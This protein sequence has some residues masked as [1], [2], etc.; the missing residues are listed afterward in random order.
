MTNFDYLKQVDALAPLHR[1]C[2]KVELLMS[3]DPEVSAL[4]ARRALDWIVKAV[5]A[6]KGERLSQRAS[7]FEM[8][9]SDTFRDFINDPE[10][11]KAVHWVRKVGNHA[12]H[13]AA[14]TASEAFYSLLNIYNVVKAILLKLRVFDSIA[15]FDRSLV[16]DRPRRPHIHVAQKPITDAVVA[17]ETPKNFAKTIDTETVEA[18]PAVVANL[19]WSDIDE[20]ETRRLLIDLMVREAGWDILADKGANHPGKA[21]IE[22]EVQGMP[23]NQGVGYCDYVLFGDNGKPLAVIEAKRCSVNPHVGEEQ[24][25][26]YA[27]CLEA[28]YGVRPVIYFTNGY[29]TWV[30]D[31][32]GYPKRKIY[33]FHSKKNLEWLI[34]QRSRHNIEDMSVKENIA[35]RHYQKTAVKR[36]C[37]HFNDMHRRGLLVMATGTGKTRTAISLVDV[38]QRAGWVKNTLFLADRILLVKQ[39]HKNFVKLLPEVT[40]TVLSDNDNIPNL[41]ARIIFSTYQTMINH[42][43]SD[44]K[45]FPVGRFDLIIIDEAHRS[46]FGK[47][48]AIFHYF[49]SLLIG[50]TATPRDQVDKSTYDLLEL[51]G[52]Q[53]NFTYELEEAVADGYLVPPVGLKRNS[54]VL[55]DGIRYNQLSASEREQL[56]KVWEYEATLGDPGTPAQPRD[57]LSRELY[58]YIF[59]DKTIDLVLQDLMANGI[60][61]DN[62]EKIGKTIIFAFNK[63]HAELIVKRFNLLYPQYGPEF[64]REIDYS[65]NYA[66]SLIEKFEQRDV[67]PQIAVSVDM[68]DTGID[69][70]DILNLVFFKRVRSRIK[71]MQMIGRGTRL[72]EDIF[73][74]GKH[75][76]NFIIF[77]YCG[78]FDYFESK[79]DEP[80]NAAVPSLS[81]RIFSTRTDIAYCLQAPEYQADAF[82]KGFH[83]NLK[84]LL[85]EQV[86]ALQDSHISVRE[87][88]ETVTTFRDSERWLCLK[89]PEVLTIK[90][91]VAPLVMGEHD[92]INALRFDLLSLY[93]QLSM[94]DDTF[95]AA[96]YE[97][98]ITRIVDL[99]HRQAAIP[100]VAA[101]IDLLNEILTSEFWNEKTLASIENMRVQVRDLLK[102]LSGEDKKTFEVDVDDTINDG[103]AASGYVPVMT[104][105]EKVM[106]YLTANSDNPVLQK[107][108]NIEQLTADD[109]NE[110]ER[111]MWQELGSK[112]DY[113]R[114]LA[115]ENL[116]T[117][118]CLVSV[119]AFIRTLIKVDHQKA[120]EKFST[121]ISENTLTADQEEY[122]K[123]ILDYVCANGDMETAALINESPFDEIS[124]LEIFPGKFQQV[125]DFVTAL[126]TT[127]TA[128]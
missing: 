59:N 19:S 100:A 88:W 95:N 16:P 13:D 82:A 34:Q 17:D 14:V 75:K 22:I 125:A 33:A 54:D 12:A 67:Q 81:E 38:L 93:V 18:A 116:H 108:K 43:D 71:F 121:Y 112:E 70:P 69:V 61:V 74:A 40:T 124:V 64:C 111:V 104:Y 127:I 101:K 76:E 85:R 96:E 4:N 84:I 8:T 48:G 30:I 51:E 102:Y 86:T 109:I 113:L 47:Y 58:K 21:G 5:F 78:N 46:V 73:G 50:L 26:F 41:D 128:A 57:I 32:M 105:R 115:S 92:D 55:N 103:G 83:D 3:S 11:M 23:N 107:I 62:G 39:A 9:D 114:F 6:M 44:E 72:S 45:T 24:A 122:L 89:A 52:G 97:A 42:V 15:N 118:V 123:S 49:D 117:G 98:K 27:D 31:G 25:R 106:D 53:P 1:Y 63:D 7:L 80:K 119:A 28:E 60:K 10:V 35:G 56:E 110:L 120:L 99:M 66:Q 2:E 87:H 126:H 90:N 65:I 29:E 79:I 36:I 77:D 91:E 37:E 68:L 94:V 20:A